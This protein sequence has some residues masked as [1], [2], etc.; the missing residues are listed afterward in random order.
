MQQWSCWCARNPSG[1][2]FPAPYT[3]TAHR[4]EF[5]DLPF[6]SWRH[7]SARQED[8][9]IA[10]VF[11][12]ISLRNCERPML[13][14]PRDGLCAVEGGM[15]DRYLHRRVCRM[16]V[17]RFHLWAHP[18]A[19]S[20][21]GILT[22]RATPHVVAITISLR[23][24][25]PLFTWTCIHGCTPPY[26]CSAV[27]SVGAPLWLFRSGSFNTSHATRRRK[28]FISPLR[29]HSIPPKYRPPGRNHPGRLRLTPP[30]APPPPPPSPEE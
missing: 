25:S 24:H 6:T 28:P 4:N 23:A 2:P 9:I 18:S 11:A 27:P 13:A 20:D 16:C 8:Q 22:L 30:P 7:S 10:R 26:V 12:I 3:H 21:R 1:A 29:A 19:C 15:G 14:L 17:A 5:P